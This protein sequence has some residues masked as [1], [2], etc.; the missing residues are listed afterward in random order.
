MH[1]CFIVV[2]RMLFHV[3]VVSYFTV[4]TFLSQRQ[5]TFHKK[6]I[7]LDLVAEMGIVDSILIDTFAFIKSLGF[8]TAALLMVAFALLIIIFKYSQELRL[9][10]KINPFS[11]NAVRKREPLVHDKEKRDAVLKQVN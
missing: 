1:K 9:S 11:N 4:V 8:S 5:V 7:R 2:T 10:G 3:T 6:K